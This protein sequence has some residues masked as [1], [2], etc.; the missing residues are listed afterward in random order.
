MAFADAM[1]DGEAALNGIV[2]KRFDAV[3]A[4]AGAAGNGE[5][6]PITAL[7]FMNILSAGS[8]LVDARL[9]KRT[10]RSARSTLR[11]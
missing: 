5:W 8:V 3:D 6:L 10:T 7:P 1:F 11:R 2:A 9:R 4:F